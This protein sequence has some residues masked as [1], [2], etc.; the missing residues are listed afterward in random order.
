MLTLT[1]RWRV[2]GQQRRVEAVADLLREAAEVFADVARRNCDREFVT[3]QASDQTG[4]RN[5]RA[6]IAREMARS[7]RSPQ[8]LPSMSLICWKPSM[9]ITSSATLR[10]FTS[11]AGN[12]RLE[13]GMKRVAVDEARQRVVFGEVS[14]SLGFALAHRNVAQDRAELKAVG[15]L[16]AG[17]G[18]LDR[19]HLAIAAASVELDHRSGGEMGGVPDRKGG[20][21]QRLRRVRKSRRTGGR[22]SPQ[23]DSRRSR[24]RRD[25]RP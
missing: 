24:S 8:V 17:E 18:G 1:R 25:S 20:C 10:P 4:R 15:A 21:W 12:V 19:K 5:Q 22:S 9:P 3:A 14:N 6:S 16:P 11:A 23:A 13:L 7:T 2:S